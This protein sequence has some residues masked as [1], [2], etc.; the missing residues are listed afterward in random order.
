MNFLLYVTGEKHQV[1]KNVSTF[2]IMP[3]CG[4]GDTETH[5]RILILLSQLRMFLFY[6]KFSTTTVNMPFWFI[7]CILQIYCYKNSTNIRP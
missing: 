7:Y 5:L 6:S 2:I 3:K 4:Y 1:S